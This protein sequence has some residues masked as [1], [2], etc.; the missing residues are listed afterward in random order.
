[1]T[2]A[3]L[4]PNRREKGAAILA[5][6]R[7]FSLQSRKTEESSELSP[8]ARGLWYSP[9]SILLLLFDPERVK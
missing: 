2:S 6:G 7:R 4:A 5:K 8:N 9:L 3:L 1:M